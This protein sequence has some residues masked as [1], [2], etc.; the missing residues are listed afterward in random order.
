MQRQFTKGF[1]LIELMLAATITTVVIGG[2]LVSVSA[3]LNAYKI[4]G[5]SGKHADTARFIFERM[6]KDLAAAFYSPHDANT[7]FVCQ[8]LQNNGIPADNLMFISTV[9]NPTETGDGTSDIVEVQ[10]YIDSDDGTPE[11]W[12]QRRY[13]PTPDMD[14]FT[15]GATALLGPSVISLDFQFYDGEMWW[16]QWDTV[17]EIPILVS[18]SIGFYTPST[19]NQEPT[20]EDIEQYSSMV[21]LAHYR[22]P[23]SDS[24][25]P[26][27]GTESLYRDAAQQGGE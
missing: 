19:I 20:P 9:N 26:V 16:Q 11:K 6:E 2:A 1:T 18:I 10:Y 21:A 22:T 12:L 13:D 14:P 4:R 5:S 15:G 17:E 3:M 23:P 25:G 24:L 8:D 27:G 7:R